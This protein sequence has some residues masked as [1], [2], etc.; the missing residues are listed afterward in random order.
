MSRACSLPEDDLESAEAER[1]DG[2]RDGEG[3]VGH[4]AGHGGR[5]LDLRPHQQV[6]R[7]LLGMVRGCHGELVNFQILDYVL[8]PNSDGPL[9]LNTA[10][11]LES[12]V[13][14]D[15]AAVALAAEAV[16]G[17]GAGRAL[18][19][20][21]AHGRRRRRVAHLSATGGQNTTLLLGNRPDDA[22]VSF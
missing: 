9:N 5:H 21:L 8:H 4:H 13:E 20:Q 18:H 2:V 10:L 15:D 22:T 14:P 11:N 1:V 3:V 12:L 19:A 17:Q 7:I 6:V 16:R